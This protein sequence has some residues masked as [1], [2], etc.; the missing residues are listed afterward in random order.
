[1]TDALTF[2][3]DTHHYWVDG[4]SK[5]HV[6][7]ILEDVGLVDST[8]FDK[9]SADRGSAVHLA[10]ELY[11][12]DDLDIDS[13]DPRI[14]AYL[15]GWI[16]FQRQ[17]G[18]RVQHVELKLHHS[19]HDYCGTVDR[20]GLYHDVPAIVDIK[21]GAIKRATGY[22]LAAYAMLALTNGLADYARRFAVHLTNDGHYKSIE[23]KE[24]IDFDVLRAALVVRQ[25]QEWR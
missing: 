2:D 14:M 8:W 3:P 5:M 12:K 24:R 9:D 6:T 25:A 4:K 13:V 22:Q 11:D 17:T 16:E 7:G 10:C 1:M 21:T 18:F 23:Y 19:L 20:I 15:D